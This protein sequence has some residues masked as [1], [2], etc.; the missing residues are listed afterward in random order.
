MLATLRRRSS[1]H[2]ILLV[3]LLAGA[4]EVD[5]WDGRGWSWL[6]VKMMAF[7]IDIEQAVERSGSNW[8]HSQH[9]DETEPLNEPQL[10]TVETQR[11]MLTMRTSVTVTSEHRRHAEKWRESAV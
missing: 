5:R 1:F 11:L 9:I 7:A 6:K 4:G 10:F 3:E 8:S 2:A